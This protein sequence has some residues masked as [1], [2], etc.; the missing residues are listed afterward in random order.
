MVENVFGILV[1]RFRVVLGSMEQRP[2]V[3]REFVFYMCGA[4]QH[5]EDTPGQSRQGINPSK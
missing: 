5:A 1:R 4:A 3:V 2:R